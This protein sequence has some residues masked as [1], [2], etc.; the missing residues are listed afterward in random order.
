MKW[1]KLPIGVAANHSNPW[2]LD[3]FPALSS[4]FANSLSYDRPT[5]TRV[6]NKQAEH[7]GDAN[8]GDVIKI[9][10]HN[11]GAIFSPATIL[12]QS[13]APSLNSVRRFASSSVGHH[14]VFFSDMICLDS[15]W[16]ADDASTQYA[17]Y[18]QCTT[19]K[20]TVGSKAVTVTVA[21]QTSAQYNSFATWCKSNYYGME[22]ILE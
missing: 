3:S 9:Y 8:G 12:F 1:P 16:L 17:P 7:W 19:Q 20:T 18:L 14:S 11:F 5:V 6:N 13:L 4:S 2:M 22:G 10:G 15:T 21:Y